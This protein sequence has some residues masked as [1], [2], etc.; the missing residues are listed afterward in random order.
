MLGLRITGAAGL[1][2]VVDAAFVDVDVGLLVVERIEVEV[3]ELDVLTG[4][5]SVE[6]VFV[7][8]VKDPLSEVVTVV[9]GAVVVVKLENELLD[10]EVLEREVLEGNV[11]DNEVLE[12]KVS[13]CD[14]LDNKVLDK[15]VLER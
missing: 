4:R 3:L 6:A 7:V 10:R 11:L 13:E 1:L 2:V 12:R 5:V 8:V 15:E 9:P 14:V